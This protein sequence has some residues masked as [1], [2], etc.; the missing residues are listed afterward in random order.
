[1]FCYFVVF[2]KIYES[3]D[4]FVIVIFFNDS[5]YIDETDTCKRQW[6]FLENVGGILNPLLKRIFN[7]HLCKE[8]HETIYSL[9]TFSNHLCKRSTNLTYEFD[10]LIP[11][12]ELLHYEVNAGKSLFSLCWDV[13][14]KKLCK[15]LRIVS[16]MHKHMPKKVVTIIKC[17]TLLKFVTFPSQMK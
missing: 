5:R 6:I 9:E 16:Q 3:F 11:Q 10:W 1:M 12:M 8:W 2:K 15:E 7:S 13:F 4:F 17:G 14:L